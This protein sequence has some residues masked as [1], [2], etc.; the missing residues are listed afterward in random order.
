MH[1]CGRR[2]DGWASPNG[3]SGARLQNETF[4][5]EISKKLRQRV[6]IQFLERSGKTARENCEELA[7]VYGAAALKP[8]TVRKWTR[9]FETG[10]E[11]VTDDKRE[12][13]PSTAT[14]KIVSKVRERVLQNR[15]GTVR[16]LSEELHMPMSTVHRML[17]EKLKMRKLCSKLV[18]RSLTHEQKEQRVECC[19][20]RI[21]AQERE[22]DYLQRVIT[23]D[24]SWF[25]EFDVERQTQ[26][27]Q[28]CRPEDT[29]P[30]RCLRSR[31]KIKIMLVVF[32]DSKGIVHHEFVPPGCTVNGLFYREVLKRLIARVARV[33]PELARNNRWILHHDNASPHSCRIVT[34]F[35]KARNVTVAEH[36]PYSPDLAPCDFFL[37]PKC[38]ALLRGRHLEDIENIK[39]QTLRQLRLIKE[40]EFR[41]CFAQWSRRWSR[42]IALHGEYFEGDRSTRDADGDRP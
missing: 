7:R 26:S 13:R 28:W 41:D 39:A 38:K 24:E 18:P 23:G 29:R 5:M 20:A 9:R 10:R 8:S 15:R 30:K 35:L 4:E 31:S 16:H 34:E 1:C 25:F 6:V 21:A 3:V 11:Q 40:D 14:G 36:P 32:F 12:G 37:F 19:R 33:R 22:P 27:A 42:C 17:R 2:N